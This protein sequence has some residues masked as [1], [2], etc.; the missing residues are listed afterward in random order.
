MTRLATA[1]RAVAA[2]GGEARWKTASAV[3]ATITSGGLALRTKWRRGFHELQVK[4]E[5]SEPRIRLR[6]I[7]RR[8]SVGVLD[9][10]AVRIENERGDVL[11]SR[12]DSRSRFPYGRRL[13]W[14]DNL[15]HVYFAGYA[16]WNY[17]TFP[18]LLLRDDIEWTE[19]AANTLEARFPPQL[20]THCEVQR[21]HFDPSTGLLRQHD[22]TA[23]V[24]GGWA[25]A[26]HVI[27]EHGT[28]KELPFPSKRHVTPRGPGGRPLPG[29]VLVWLEVR[30]WRLLSKD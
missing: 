10:H 25:K 3:E 28:W 1:E 14:W 24:F 11:A 9:G 5:V 22:Y 12:S 13:L 20:P 30:D 6:P 19:D 17:L 15:D 16:M 27:L 4:A 2:Y 29:P 21:F 23:E 8:G 18:A 26:A 7:D